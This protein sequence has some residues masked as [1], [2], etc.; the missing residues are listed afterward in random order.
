MNESI[1]QAL[2]LIFMFIIGA[3]MGSFAC[4]QARRLHE[5]NLG[6]T[7]GH[8]SVCLHCGHRLKWY[9][10]I[11]LF[12]WL[13]LRGKCSKC[14]KKIGASEI[15]AE[16]GTALAFL[17]LGTTISFQWS[18][19]EWSMFVVLLI[20]I[21]IMAILAIYDSLWKQ[22]PNFLLILVNACAILYFCL[23][24]IGLCL[25]LFPPQSIMGISGAA[26]EVINVLLAIGLLAGLYFL[27]YFFSHE[28][29]V[30]AGDWILGLA[31]ALF[32]S[33][34]WLALVTL[35]IAN[36]SASIIALPLLF[37]Q[38]TKQIKKSNQKIRNTQIPFG[39]FL[40]FGFI[41]VWVLQ[42]WLLKLVVF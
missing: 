17:A 5:K 41:V 10:N 11:P 34:W 21:V 18:V 24:I 31:L 20:G 7:Y 3:M 22:L 40:I 27:L 15:F 37:H 14:G 23:R 12:S 29:L 30:G 38:K 35:F 28:K 1:P 19:L 33:N 36:F 13:F 2:L 42:T 6:K 4:C 26:G 32:L 39:P 16:V 9:E 8:W 25:R